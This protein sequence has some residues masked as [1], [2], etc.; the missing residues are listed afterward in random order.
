MD[1]LVPTEVCPSSSVSDKASQAACSIRATI[2]GVAKTS[3]LPLPTARAV[4]CSATTVLA[5]AD[6]PFSVLGVGAEFEI[7]INLFP[8]DFHEHAL[9]AHSV[10]LAVEDLFPCSEV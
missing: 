8:D 4:L 2:I 6:L 10:K 1:M 3:K 7:V 9:V 5:V